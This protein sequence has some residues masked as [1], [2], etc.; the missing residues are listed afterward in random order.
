[1]DPAHIG[2]AIIAVGIVGLIVVFGRSSRHDPPKSAAPASGSS[3]DATPLAAPPTGSRVVRPPETQTAPPSTARP[4]PSSSLGAAAQKVASKPKAT[5]SK[6]TAPPPDHVGPYQIQGLVGEGAMACVY[7]A[8]DK[9]NQ[10]IVALKLVQAGLQKDPEFLARFQREME[11]SQKLN[12]PNIVR[13]YE[14]GEHDGQLYMT[15]EL[16]DG[17]TLD[18]MLAEGPLPLHQVVRIAGQLVDGLHYAHQRDLIH[19][20][21]KPNNVMVTRNGIPKILDFGLALQQ[22]MNRFTHV[23]M[24]MGTPTHMAPEALTT[25]NSDKKSDQYALGVVLFQMLTGQCPFQGPDAMSIAMQHVK[26]PPP[27]ISALRPE[28]PARLELIIMRMLRK[29]PEDRYPNLTQLQMEI[30]AVV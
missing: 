23:G 13:V 27:S 29:K 3:P 6:S 28:V 30:V 12:H 4:S 8:E 24:A 18:E 20:D 14:T 15:M 9:R 26:N 22:G 17:A 19:R 10:K 7:R 25:G 16:V 5:P 11:I 1:M 2:V 21:I